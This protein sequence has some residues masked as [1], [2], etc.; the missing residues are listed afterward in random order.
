MLCWRCYCDIADGSHCMRIQSMFTIIKVKV[1]KKAVYKS[2]WTP[3]RVLDLRITGVLVDLKTS[4]QEGHTYIQTTSTAP[5][6]TSTRLRPRPPSKPSSPSCLHHRRRRRRHSWTS[7]A[8]SPNAS[9]GISSPTRSRHS[10]RIQ[11]LRLSRS[12]CGRTSSRACR[13]SLTRDD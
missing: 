8:R 13:P 7:S 1:R 5:P 3:S 12:S 9:Y 4:I 6:W 10:C 11:R 2:T